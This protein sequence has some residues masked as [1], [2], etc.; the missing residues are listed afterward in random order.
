MIVDDYRPPTTEELPKEWTEYRHRGLPFMELPDGTVR[1]L[2]AGA[3]QAFE[4]ED[5]ADRHIDEHYAD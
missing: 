3:W 2:I 1:V 4:D 5:A